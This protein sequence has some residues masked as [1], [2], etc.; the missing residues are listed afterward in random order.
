MVEDVFNDYFAA[1]GEPTDPTELDG[2]TDYASFTDLGIP[3]GGVT[4]G[5]EVPKTAEQQAR[6][7]GVGGQP[8]YVCYHEACDTVATIFGSAGNPFV[9]PP[10][11]PALRVFTNAGLG[12][13]TLTDQAGGAAHA[14]LTF[15][16]TTSAVNGTDKA[17]TLAT[18]KGDREYLGSRLR[19]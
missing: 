8:Y 5:A 3:A 1:L 18:A 13:D 4:A 9:P 6:Y 15:A 2:R 17:S 12:E 10:S 19:K 11:D 14:V 16:Q 7:G